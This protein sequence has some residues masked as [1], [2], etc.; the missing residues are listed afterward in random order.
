ME[1]N[2]KQAVLA[3][4]VL[5]LTG[6]NSLPFGKTDPASQPKLAP[7]QLPDYL[8]GEYFIFNNKTMYTVTGKK[9]GMITWETNTGLTKVNTSNFLIP[10]LK[11]HRKSR[12][13]EGHT[14][15]P[16]DIMWPL[17]TGNRAEIH[18]QQTITKTD[19]SEPT[20]ITR[21]WRCEVEGTERITVQAGTF[22]TYRT[23]CTRNSPTSGRFRASKTYYYAPTVGHYVLIE[24]LHKYK[25]KKRK[26]LT[27]YGFNST[28]L[29]SRDEKTLK[30][31]LQSVLNKHSDGAAGSWTSR[32]GQVTAMLVP[33]N[34]HKLPSG[35]KCREYRSIY[36]AGGRI[37][38]KHERRMC[39][40]RKNGLWTIN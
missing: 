40:D 25:P 14:P 9:K 23:L 8:P 39:K 37:G 36:S 31:K 15:A 28:Y 27:A 16:H 2:I 30:R 29:P 21:D 38:N 3:C 1:K 22:D 13:S 7:A 6:C 10:D 4:S 33:F 32:N 34:S 11:W 35:Q 12:S 26:E 18:F 5:V 24:E 20:V 19:G 17:K